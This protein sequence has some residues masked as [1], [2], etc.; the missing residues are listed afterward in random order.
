[1]QHEKNANSNQQQELE[2]QIKSAKTECVQAEAAR[3]QVET[4]LVEIERIAETTRCN[5]AEANLEVK[6]IIFASRPNFSQVN[7]LSEP[8][9]FRLPLFTGHFDD[10]RDASASTMNSV[11]SWCHKTNEQFQSYAKTSKVFNFYPQVPSY[12]RLYFTEIIWW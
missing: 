10:I 12:K 2:A 6:H 8:S 11:R 5:L 1:M 4:R 7:L 9:S 3:R